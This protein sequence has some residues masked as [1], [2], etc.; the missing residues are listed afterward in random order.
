[1]RRH[2]HAKGM[3]GRT[4]GLR[5]PGQIYLR[6]ERPNPMFS[7]SA[8]C[9]GRIGELLCVVGPSPVSCPGRNSAG[10]Q[11]TEFAQSLR[12]RDCHVRSPGTTWPMALFC[13]LGDILLWY[14]V[15]FGGGSLE[16]DRSKFSSLAQVRRGDVTLVCRTRQPQR[17]ICFY[18][19]GKPH[20]A[21]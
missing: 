4:H 1:M 16:A 15:R 11:P 8:Q 19:R 20:W 3:R 6:I 14:A 18:R 2:A 10:L 12:R 9:R 13:P 5:V 7:A 17:R 21:P